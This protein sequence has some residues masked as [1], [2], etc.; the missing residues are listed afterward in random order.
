[1]VDYTSD[2]ESQ[3]GDTG[4]EYSIIPLGIYILAAG[5]PIVSMV[6]EHTCLPVGKSMMVCST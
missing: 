6:K 3:I 4:K 1:M 5:I 2:R